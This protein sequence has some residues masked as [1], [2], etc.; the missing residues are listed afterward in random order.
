MILKFIIIRRIRIKEM[1]IKYGKEK[2]KPK[3]IFA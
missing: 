2:I 3:T 1:E